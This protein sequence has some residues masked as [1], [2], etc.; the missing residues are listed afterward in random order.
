MAMTS[1]CEEI[2]NQLSIIEAFEK[3]TDVMIPST[4]GNKKQFNICCPF[5]DDKNPSLTIY[6][7]SN[8]WYCHVGCGGGDVINLVSKAMNL[9]NVEAI[10]LLAKDMGISMNQQLDAETYKINRGI[11][12]FNHHCMLYADALNDLKITLLD[13]AR[14][15]TEIKELEQKGDIYHSLARIEYLAPL[16]QFGSVEDKIYAIRKIGEM[17]NHGSGNP[18]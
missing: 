7:H 12:E 13:E 3:Y 1:A 17:I 5:H 6:S 2:K 9:S 14:T 4:K 10:K 11:K 15:I 16:V 18:E 8:R